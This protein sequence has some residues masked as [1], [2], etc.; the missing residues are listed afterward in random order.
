MCVCLVNLRNEFVSDRGGLDYGLPLFICLISDSLDI[1]EVSNSFTAFV[2]KYFAVKLYSV[3]L[4]DFRIRLHLLPVNLT[5][6]KSAVRG[7]NENYLCMSL[8]YQ[9]PR[10]DKFLRINQR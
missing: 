4:S 10:K 9:S 5:I 6:V 1:I 8:K 2:P 7:H 3:L